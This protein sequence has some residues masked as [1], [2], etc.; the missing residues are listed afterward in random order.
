[1]HNPYPP[2]SLRER[3]SLPVPLPVRQGA[4]NPKTGT[5]NRKFVVNAPLKKLSEFIAEYKPIS[6]EGERARPPYGKWT[7]EDGSQVLFNRSYRPI[8]QRSPDG[9]VSEADPRKWV[10]SIVSDV[11]FWDDSTKKDAKARAVRKALNDWG[12]AWAWYA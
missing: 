5:E 7:C 1:M 2:R 12:L 4:S 9:F 8:Y 3:R 10:E 11:F 6:P